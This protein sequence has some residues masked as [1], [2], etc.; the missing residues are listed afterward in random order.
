[1]M[2]QLRM[3]WAFL[4]QFIAAWLALDKPTR[5]LA[6]LL[7]YIVKDLPDIGDHS[8]LRVVLLAYLCE[9]ESYRSYGETITGATWIRGKEGPVPEKLPE[10][11]TWLLN[12]ELVTLEE[13]GA[14]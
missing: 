8:L 7:R 12:Q 14:S 1:M 5:K 2:L 11:M 10:A 13:I 6:A 9:V 4:R 3:C